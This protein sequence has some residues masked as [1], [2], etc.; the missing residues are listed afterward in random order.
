MRSRFSG[1]QKQKQRISQIRILRIS[2]HSLF[3]NANYSVNHS[4]ITDYK[5][6]CRA[7]IGLKGKN[8]GIKKSKKSHEVNIQSNAP[9]YT[10]PTYIPLENTQ[11]PIVQHHIH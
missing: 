10:E 4:I 6:A 7:D 5:M 3:R 9:I 11:Q 8:V 2:Y 1:S